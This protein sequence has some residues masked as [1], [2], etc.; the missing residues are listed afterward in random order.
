[1]S[2][3]TAEKE[4][5]NDSGSMRERGAFVPRVQEVPAKLREVLQEERRVR[6]VVMDRCAGSCM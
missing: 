1:M 5:M 6:A 3:E 4:S 2:G